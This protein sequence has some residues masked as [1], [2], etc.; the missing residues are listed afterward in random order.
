MLG[1][2]PLTVIRQKILAKIQTKYNIDAENMNQLS[3]YFESNNDSDKEL[4]KQRR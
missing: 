4:E 3:L 2:E 1:F